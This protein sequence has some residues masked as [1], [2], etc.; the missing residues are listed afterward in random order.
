MGHVSGSSW[1]PMGSPGGPK[2]DQ[3]FSYFDTF[4]GEMPD[5]GSGSVLRLMDRG[6][7]SMVGDTPWL[8]PARKARKARKS[9][10]KMMVEWDLMGWIPSAYD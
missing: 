9:H 5:L 2:E 3:I 8:C 6:G 1:D 4:T 10:R 7:G